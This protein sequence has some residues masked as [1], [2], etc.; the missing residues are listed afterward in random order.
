M[1]DAGGPITGEEYHERL[2]LLAKS[3]AAG[4]R[5][6][7]LAADGGSS[8]DVGGALC[9]YSTSYVPVF[10]GAAILNEA[11]FC[12][13]TIDLIERYFRHRG[14]PYSIMTL[15][16]L[17]PRAADMLVP[18]NYA[19]YDSMPAMWLEGEPDSEP[20]ASREIWVRQVD[21]PVPLSVFRKI[22][23]TVFHL[24]M[25]EVNLVLGERTLEIEH[26]KHYLGWLG[27]TPVGTASLVLSDGVAGVW[28]VGTLSEY[29]HRGVAAT[30]MH[31]ILSEA[32]MLGYRDSM[33]LASNE[34][35]PLY[36]RLGYKTL[37]H[38]RVFVPT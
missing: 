34:G 7:S 38:I 31:H 15:D 28:N 24:S 30:L 18:F 9:W 10:N 11:L 29:R 36:E 17:V 25:T 5:S 13:P 23:S 33:L 6:L 8:E 22:L 2:L 32:R 16:A 12:Y 4:F 14:R 1:Q 35:Q 21:S 37:S 19:E 26:V 3:A 27:N 20:P